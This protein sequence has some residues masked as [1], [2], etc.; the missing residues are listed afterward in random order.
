MRYLALILVVAL[1]CASAPPT[2]AIPEGKVAFRFRTLDGEAV[3]LAQFRGRPVA[4][5][6]FTTWSG[7]ALLEVER[8]A[9]AQRRYGDNLVT[10]GV[11]LDKDPEMARIFADTYNPPFVLLRVDDPAHFTGTDGPFGP[12]GLLPTSVIL[13]KS[14]VVAVRSDGVWPAGALFTALAELADDPKGK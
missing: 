7:P 8:F 13:D 4:V 10:L 2:V 6:I 3:S 11:M 14:G 9:Q 1:G 5:L 12:I